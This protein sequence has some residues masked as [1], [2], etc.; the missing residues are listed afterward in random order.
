MYID[1]QI[2]TKCISKLL[3]ISLI[4]CSTVVIIPSSVYAVS[5]ADSISA[6]S[7]GDSH[8]S[9]I[10]TDGSLWTWGENDRGQLGIG[11]NV[12]SNTPIKVMD[13]VKAVSLGAAQTAAI[14]ND[15]SLWICG[16]NHWGQLGN[17]NNNKAPFTFY[18]VQDNDWSDNGQHG[19]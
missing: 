18:Y 7:V 4:I 12:N 16:L 13:G 17:G 8:S 19:W 6:V 5:S 14:K 2:I 10:K 15:G 9:V 3:V 11:N 1:Y